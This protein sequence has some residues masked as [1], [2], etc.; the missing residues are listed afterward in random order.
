[1]RTEPTDI[2]HR[3]QNKLCEKLGEKGFSFVAFGMF[4]V[5]GWPEGRYVAVYRRPELPSREQVADLVAK[6]AEQPFPSVPKGA[7]ALVLVEDANLVLV[8]RK[9]IETG[10]KLGIVQA[11]ASTT[12]E[13]MPKG[14]LN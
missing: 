8:E 14:A 10:E 4:G 1:M 11:M 6:M 2:H 9:E 7:L 5:K 3:V 13:L 12:I